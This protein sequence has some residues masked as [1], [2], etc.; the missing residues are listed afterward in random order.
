MIHILYHSSIYNVQVN[1]LQHSHLDGWLSLQ[2]LLRHYHH[3]LNKP[4]VHYRSL[5]YSLPLR[6]FFFRNFMKMSHAICKRCL[7][8]STLLSKFISHH[9]TSQP[10]MHF[11][12]QELS[13]V[14]T[15]HFVFTHL[16]VCGHLGSL[17][18]SVINNDAVMHVD[19]QVLCGNIC[20]SLGSCLTIWGTANY[21]PKQ[22]YHCLS[23]L[24]LTGRFSSLS[25]Y[26][27]WFFF[28]CS[29]LY[30]VWRNTLL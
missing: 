21:F 26:Y 11:Y 20:A 15:S 4:Y 13:K 10:F 14:S 19:V 24:H 16:S 25:I 30:A 22:L 17:Y 8:F 3:P 2:S 1:G 23:P 7:L 28:Y 27:L 18:H 29:H 5:W 6:I 12:C 9:G